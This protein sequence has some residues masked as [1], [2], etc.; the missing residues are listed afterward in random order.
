MYQQYVV[1]RSMIIGKSQHPTDRT[2]SPTPYNNT[3]DRPDEFTL[4]DT[5][6]TFVLG[7]NVPSVLDLNR[8]VNNLC[9]TVVG[10]NGTYEDN[11]GSNLGW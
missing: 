8:I 2:S 9:S 7:D 10:W 5:S 3:F 6:R 1:F 11:L 4:G